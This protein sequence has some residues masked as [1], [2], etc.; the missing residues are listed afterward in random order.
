MPNSPLEAE[1][2][3][4]YGMLFGQDCNTHSPRYGYKGSKPSENYLILRLF[5]GKIV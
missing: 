2:T 1:I 4:P 5:L 3:P